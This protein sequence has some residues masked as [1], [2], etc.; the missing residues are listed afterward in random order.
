MSAPNTILLKCKGHR[1]EYP[2][3]AELYPGHLLMVNSTN[4]VLKHNQVGA[5]GPV[6]V[7]CE[8]AL[9]GKTIDDA[10]AAADVVPVIV[11]VKGDIIN[12][13]LQ[14]GQNV[15]N[16][17]GLVSAGDGT[18]IAGGDVDAI[19]SGLV[20]RSV[21]ASTAYTT[22]STET[23]FD[24]YYTVPANSLRAGDVLIVKA[25]VIATATNSTD[26][27]TLKLY[28]G[29]LAGTAICSSGAVD[30]ANGDIGLIVANITIRTIGASGT[31]VAN[32]T[33]SLGVP[34]TVTPK[35]FLL[36]STAIDTTTSK[37]IGVSGTFS[38]T[39]AG[40]SARLDSLTVN[41]ERV[42]GDEPLMIAGEAKDATSAEKF[43]RARVA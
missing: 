19:P 4:E 13:R 36:G 17:A 15:L 21:A 30:V 8:Q 34:G 43:I 26:T 18:L 10:F 3:D 28:I 27:L 33:T 24:K 16:G 6:I 2:A 37:V 1:E 40:N 41:V 5:H 32:G 42:G 12:V 22:S 25:Q 11:G 31:F 20:Y 39:N 14:V 38:T 9:L 29:G 35:A 7:A 23:L